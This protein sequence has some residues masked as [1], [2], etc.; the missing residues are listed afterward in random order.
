MLLFC[1]V[2]RPFRLSGHDRQPGMGKTTL[3]FQLLHRFNPW[4]ERRSSYKQNAI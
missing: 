1:T 3:L 4:D 2:Y